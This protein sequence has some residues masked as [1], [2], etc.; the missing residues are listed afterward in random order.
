MQDVQ[1]NRGV[2]FVETHVYLTPD[3]KEKFLKVAGKLGFTAVFA[4]GEKRGVGEG[5]EV[6]SRVNLEGG[7]LV[8]MKKT[9]GK[10]RGKGDLVA[11]PCISREVAVWAARNPDIDILYFPSIECYKYLDKSLVRLSQEGGVAIEL[12]L[13]PLFTSDGVK[14]I[15]AFS[16]LRRAASILLE[17]GAVF[18]I[19][20]EP[21]SY[22]EVRS[23][24]SITAI[25]LLLGIPREAAL[26]ALSF[27]PF[28]VLEWRGYEGVQRVS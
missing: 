22:Y 12:S 19:T 11:A 20:R 14:R 5:V 23:P 16:V 3:S 25:A 13:A 26:K 9:L 4:V 6:F 24:T 10:V 28:L 17:E 2:R 18:F 21:R 8:Q 1:F 27:Y 7:R 15:R